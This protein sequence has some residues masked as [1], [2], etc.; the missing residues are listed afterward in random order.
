[1]DAVDLALCVPDR[2]RG[3]SLGDAIGRQTNA[4]GR[5]RTGV[6]VRA[7]CVP[8]R[9]IGRTMVTTAHYVADSNPRGGSLPIPFP[10]DAR[11][12]VRARESAI[13]RRSPS[14]TPRLGFEPRSPVEDARLASE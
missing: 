14:A 3:E 2:F 7:T 4:V 9:A 13:G 1:M 6:P 11:P 10:Y 5:I 8:D 12:P